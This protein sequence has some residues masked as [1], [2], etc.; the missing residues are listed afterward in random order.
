[1]DKGSSRGG[2]KQ[3]SISRREEPCS[4]LGDCIGVEFH[5]RIT[6]HDAPFLQEMDKVLYEMD[7][8]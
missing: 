1:M 8:V 5:N 4:Y 7:K 3:G 2:G 6:D